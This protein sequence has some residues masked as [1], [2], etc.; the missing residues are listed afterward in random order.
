M[1][2]ALAELFG[3]LGTVPTRSEYTHILRDILYHVRTPDGLRHC[4]YGW[5]EGVEHGLLYVRE[6]DGTL[7]RIMATIEQYVGV[8]EIE[9]KA[10]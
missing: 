6:L 10:P 3:R 8:D 4:I 2:A 1:M 7:K 9:L 5:T